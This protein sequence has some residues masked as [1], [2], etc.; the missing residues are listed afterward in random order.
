MIV[1]K[2]KPAILR[3]NKETSLIFTYTSHKFEVTFISHL[4]F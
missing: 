4:G 3:Y 2:C 1:K